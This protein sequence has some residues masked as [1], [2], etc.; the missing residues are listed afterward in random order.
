MRIAGECIAQV[1]NPSQATD[2]RAGKPADAGAGGETSFMVLQAQPACM[3]VD[4]TE[5]A[6]GSGRP[7]RILLQADH[8][9]RVKHR[10]IR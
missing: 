4:V 6:I 8:G 9:E 1:V 10:A 5:L 7:W 2:D 3:V